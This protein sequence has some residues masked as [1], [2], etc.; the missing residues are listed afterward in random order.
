MPPM[1]ES[2]RQL[3]PLH[4]GEY[5]RDLILERGL[6]QHHLEEAIKVSHTGVSLVINGRRDISPAMA[7]RLEIATGIDAAEWIRMQ[8]EVT[9]WRERRKRAGQLRAVTALPP[10]PPAAAD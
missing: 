7:L 2:M 8:M 9:L 1:S 5:L 4:P 10:T 6:K 3:Q